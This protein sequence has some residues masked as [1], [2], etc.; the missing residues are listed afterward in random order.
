M[1][2]DRDHILESSVPTTLLSSV[3][4][5]PDVAIPRARPQETLG[6]RRFF[7]FDFFN[8][9]NVHALLHL[10]AAARGG[11]ALCYFGQRNL[12]AFNVII[13]ICFEDGVEWIA[14]MPISTTTNEDNQYLK[15][16]YATLLFLQDLKGAVPAPRP[17]GYCFNRQ[18]PANT[19]YIFMDKISGMPLSDAISNGHMN[20]EAVHR[21]LSDLAA[22]K[23]ALSMH[24]FM[25]IG[26]LTLFIDESAKC[27]HFGV[28]RQYTMSSRQSDHS[29]YP[30]DFGPYQS[31]L[32]Y[33]STLLHNSWNEWME[34]QYEEEVKPLAER[35]RLQAYLTSIIASYA[36][37]AQEFHLTHTDLHPGNIFVDDQGNITAIIDWEFAS[38]L[39]SQGSENYPSLLANDL[40]FIVQNSHVYPDAAAE[41]SHWKE[42]YAKQWE[43]DVEMQE[44]FANIEKI[45][46]FED[47]L[48]NAEAAN[49]QNVVERVKL[50]DSSSTLE[51]IEIPFPW[52][53]PTVIHT[54]Y[55]VVQGWTGNRRRRKGIKE[56]ITRVYH[57]LFPRG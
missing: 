32:H 8:K 21:M 13:A 43:S 40:E 52:T 2:D 20:R 49:I 5:Y 37:P 54:P 15:S 1:A 28:G 17:H 4:Q 33:Y 41:I 55:R 27:T 31:S 19:P 34:Y 11:T 46:D 45:I 16:E 53:A 7:E 30:S 22:R 6:Q 51:N 3:N 14:K 48:R 10:A 50:V 38:T 36:K 18:N 42:F 56:V 39:P 24:P 12:G 29:R 9:I 25:E 47:L 26:S 44:Y 35:L 57:R 23:K